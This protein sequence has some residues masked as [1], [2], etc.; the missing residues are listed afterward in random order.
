MERRIVNGEWR[1]ANG[2]LCI[3]R[4]AVILFVVTIVAAC[5][6]PEPQPLIFNPVPWQAGEGS[7]FDVTDLNGQYAGTTVYTMAASG[8]SKPGSWLIRRETNTQGDHETV[9]SEITDRFFRPLQVNWSLEN[10]GSVE[11]IDAKFVDGAV[12]MVL[13]SKQRQVHTE[14]RTIPTD[15]YDAYSLMMLLR[16]LPLADDYA[17]ELT[18]FTLL[19]G[20][21]EFVTVRVLQQEDVTVPLDTFHTWALEL[22][23]GDKKSQVW[24]G[25]EAPYPVVKYIDA[26]NGGT[27]ALSSF[28]TGK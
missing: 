5:G 14:Q 17:T 25:T 24:I 9:E 2:R 26:R 13:T 18:M 6:R 7:L 22:Q 10:N 27:Y 23:N 3:R 28:E 11:T 8:A 21:L 15:S 16:A 4:W 20:Q 1:M 19:T 12:D